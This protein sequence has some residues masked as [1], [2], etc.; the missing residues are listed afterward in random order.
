MKSENKLVLIE[1]IRVDLDS[2][3]GISHRFDPDRCGKSGCCCSH[4]EVSLEHGELQRLVDWQPLAA[5]FQP[6]LAEDEN[7]FPFDQD[8]G[9]QWVIEAGEEG[10]CP[11][12]YVN[13][14]GQ[15][16]CSIHSAALAQGKNPFHIKPRS[17]T[18]WPLAISEDDPPILSVPDGILDFPC[19][20]K[21]SLR[22]LSPGIAELIE[23]VFG[24]SFC[25]AVA[26]A[27][28]DLERFCG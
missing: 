10:T 21:K 18:L 4:Y 20:R 23:N 6:Q 16:F 25:K 19:N 12:A 17:C 9:G 15:T 24:A 22:Q 14:E 28:L 26:K 3:A 13:R 11:F 8:D 7:D 27:I 1:G 2:I 5:K